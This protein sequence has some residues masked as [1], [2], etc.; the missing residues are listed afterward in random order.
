M[1]TWV[2]TCAHVCRWPHCPEKGIRFPGD[3]IL[4]G[5]NL[6]GSHPQELHMLLTA[7]PSLQPLSLV[8]SAKGIK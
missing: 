7:E 3:V 4:G 6:S 2:L 5:G 1:C 8:I